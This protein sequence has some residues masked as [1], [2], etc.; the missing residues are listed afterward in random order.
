MY[1]ET[2]IFDE[3]P[4]PLSACQMGNPDCSYIIE[5]EGYEEKARFYW[6]CE[7]H[8]VQGR[9]ATKEEVWRHHGER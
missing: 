8:G 6:V 5:Q 9:R 3:D 7:T 4:G 2:D 1:D